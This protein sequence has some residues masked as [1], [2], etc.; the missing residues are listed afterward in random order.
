MQPED[1]E[2]GRGC[3]IRP[4]PRGDPGEAAHGVAEGQ[5]EENGGRIDKMTT[6]AVDWARQVAQIERGDIAPI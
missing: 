2:T 1:R 3:R 5:A 4:R 6:W